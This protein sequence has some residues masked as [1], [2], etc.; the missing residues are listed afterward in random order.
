MSTISFHTP[1][2][3]QCVSS[4]NDSNSKKNNTKENLIIPVSISTLF[5]N[6]LGLR[7]LLLHSSSIDGLHQN[8]D[9]KTRWWI[10]PPSF[11]TD[12]FHNRHGT[13]HG[14]FAL[15]LLITFCKLHVGLLYGEDSDVIKKASVQYLRPVNISSPLAVRTCLENVDKNKVRATVELYTQEKQSKKFVLG[16][17]SM[18]CRAFIT[19]AR[20]SSVQSHL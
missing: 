18:L 12:W 1:I 8:S 6:K 5:A 9:E 3:S 16:A 20:G 15:A 4:N 19:I 7:N 10:I 13:L 17:S 14:G 11:L 2:E